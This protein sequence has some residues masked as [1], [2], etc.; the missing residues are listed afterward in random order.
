[1]AYAFI[2]NG[3]S[4]AAMGIRLR[5]MTD[6]VRPEERVEHVK[7]P[8]RSGELTQLEGEDVFNGYIQP[9]HISVVGHDKVRAVEKWLSGGGTVSFPAQPEYQQNA[10]VMGAVVLRKI[11]HNLDVWEGEVQFYCEPL[12]AAVTTEQDIE[13]TTS[14]ATVTNPGDVDAKPR[15]EITGSGDIT[16]QMGGN[17]LVLT[18]VTTGMVI[19]SD[20]EWVLK[21]GVP[22]QGVYTGKFPVL[23][24][25]DNT[26]AFTGSV[27]K[28]T[29][30]PRWRYL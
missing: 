11:S 23:K 15:I 4:S 2:W 8:G 14:G 13:V 10:R 3:V 17:A 27:T 9:V 30:T 21:N 18:G 6:I 1:M 20:T 28:L 19:D 16:I 25:G 5:T 26:V 24:P 29:I 7:V 12:K 22:Q